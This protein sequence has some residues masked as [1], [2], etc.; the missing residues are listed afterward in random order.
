VRI[1]RWHVI[2]VAPSA[3]H[4]SGLVV[5]VSTTGLIEMDHTEYVTGIIHEAE[6]FP[7]EWYWGHYYNRRE[8]GARARAKAVEDFEQ[9][10]KPLVETRER[11]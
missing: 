4:D 11:V 9:R 7:T 6:P 8:H 2:A 1:G 10:S 5:L 3:Q